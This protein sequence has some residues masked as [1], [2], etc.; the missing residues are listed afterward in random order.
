MSYNKRRF[1][2]KLKALFYLLLLH[3]Q[4]GLAAASARQRRHIL[5]VVYNRRATHRPL[6]RANKNFPRTATRADAGVVA[7]SSEPL[8]RQRRLNVLFHVEMIACDNHDC[9]PHNVLAEDH[10]RETAERETS[11]T[12]PVSWKIR[13]LA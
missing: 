5:P 9:N 1:N 12:G 3:V 4:E 8:L 7:A 6:R 2:K 13:E 10:L 11:N